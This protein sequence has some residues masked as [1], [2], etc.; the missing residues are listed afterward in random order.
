M[1]WRRAR[2][3][4]RLRIESK[5]TTRHARIVLFEVTMSTHVLAVTTLL[6]LAAGCASQPTPKPASLDPSNPAAEEAPR[7]QVT[8]LPA[9]TS[10]APTAAASANDHSASGHEPAAAEKAVYTC[11]MHPEVVSPEP[12]KCPKC[13]MTLVLKQPTA[14]DRK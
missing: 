3:P 7:S 1:L 8:P 5:R 12:G 11:P 2:H 14:G 13:G 4:G 6:S 10:A 9:S